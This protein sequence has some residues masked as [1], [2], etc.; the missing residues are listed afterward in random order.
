VDRANTAVVP[1][2]ARQDDGFRT[3]ILIDQIVEASQRYVQAV[4]GETE[5]EFATTAY[6]VAY[7]LLLDARTRGLDTIA[8]KYRQSIQSRLSRAA[9]RATPGPTMPKNPRSADLVEQDLGI[10]TD[11]IT[12][13]TGVDPVPPPPDAGSPDALR[14]IKQGVARALEVREQSSPQTARAT[15]EQAVGIN[16]PV[17]G[18]GIASVDPTML[19][20]IERALFIDFPAAL[21]GKDEPTAIA[22]QLDARLDDAIQ[23]VESELEL[24]RNGDG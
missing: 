2:N 9:D 12:N 20:E 22:E 4:D 1:A 5:P 16:M 11:A 3:A 6:Q 23:L 24:L 14:A 17:A 19:A 18:R 15:L 21:N 7:G 13:V 10:I 8:T